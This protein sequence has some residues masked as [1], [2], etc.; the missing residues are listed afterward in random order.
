MS[1]DT[2]GN[3]EAVDTEKQAQLK[4]RPENKKLTHL[5]RIVMQIFVVYCKFPAG[6][7]RCPVNGGIKHFAVVIHGIGNGVQSYCQLNKEKENHSHCQYKISFAYKKVTETGV[8][9]QRRSHSSGKDQ[10]NSAL[11]PGAI[12]ENRIVQPDCQKYK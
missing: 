6:I 11:Y 12:P 10:H 5:L 2:G 9:R 4:D 8:N 7:A 3:I 1:H